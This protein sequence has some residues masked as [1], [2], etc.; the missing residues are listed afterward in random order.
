MVGIVPANITAKLVTARFC[1]LIMHLIA[2]YIFVLNKIPLIQL[3][4]GPGKSVVERHEQY[5]KI[6][7]WLEFAS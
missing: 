3:E 6:N 5:R 4:L 2:T 1:A 7:A